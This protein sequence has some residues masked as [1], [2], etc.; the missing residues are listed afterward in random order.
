MI[1]R[2]KV[3]GVLDEIADE[4]HLAELAEQN[5]RAIN[6]SVLRDIYKLLKESLN[7]VH[8]KNC[9]HDKYCDKAGKYSDWFCADGERRQ[10][11]DPSQD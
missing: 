5:Y 4:I 8:C 10:E 2:K 6:L 9:K 1:D 3:W 11:D 7:I